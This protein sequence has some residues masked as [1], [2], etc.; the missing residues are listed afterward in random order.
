[1]AKIYYSIDTSSIGY[2]VHW[3]DELGREHVERIN[4]ERIGFDSAD[5]DKEFQIAHPGA[6]WLKWDR[7]CTRCAWA[8]T[9]RAKLL[10]WNAWAK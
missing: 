1:M 9:E 8:E 3:L 2:P 10:A 4:I 6:V 5:V 7:F